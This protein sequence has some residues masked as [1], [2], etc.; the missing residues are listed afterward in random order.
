MEPETRK[1]NPLLRVLEA[2]ADIAIVGILWALCSLPVITL[3]AATVGAYRAG[4]VLS[5][6]KHSLSREFFRAFRENFR[7]ATVMELLLLAGG[8][9]LWLDLRILKA[10]KVSGVSV[11]LIVL[12][13]VWYLIALVV[14]PLMSRYDNTLSHHL[15]N[16]AAMVLL[17]LPRCA[18]L[19]AFSALPVLLFALNPQMFLNFALPIVLVFWPGCYFLGSGHLM[20]KMFLRFERTPAAGEG[21][22]DLS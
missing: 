16:A 21:K 10:L 7:Q 9:I 19:L 13:A 8:G 2:I 5:E 12:A 20:K 1:G 3:G 6:P 22:D 11:V 14:F 17:N 18:L 15:R 4:G